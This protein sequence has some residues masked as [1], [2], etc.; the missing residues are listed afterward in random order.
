MRK[1]IRSNIQKIVHTA[2]KRPR[3]VQWVI[4]ID[5]VG[6]GPIAGPVTLCAFAVRVEF[7]KD[8]NA[9]GFK[10]SKKI[11]PQKREQFAQ[12]LNNC[13]QLHMCTWSIE[14]TS[15]E[16]IDS[17]GLTL[18]INSALSRCLKKLDIHPEYVDIYLDGGLK[19]PKEYFR[20]HTVIHGDDLFPVISCASI[21]GKVYRDRL[22]EKHDKDYPEYGFFDNKG[23]GTPEH[24]KA[25]KKHG[26][27]PLHRRSF[28]KK[29]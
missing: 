13:A 16:H 11:S 26:M 17:K 9:M 21:L 19:A 25:V 12:I 5:E 27:S 28:L 20:Q 22:M 23:Y 2:S 24:M 10:D 1:K 29:F 8:L 4:G 15:A 18:A 3:K 14:S 7:L 6:R